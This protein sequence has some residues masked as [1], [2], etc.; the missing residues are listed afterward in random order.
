[1]AVDTADKRITSAFFGMPHLAGVRRPTASWSVFLRGSTIG[2]YH[3]DSIAP[4]DAPGN[5]SSGWTIG[6]A[7]RT[8]RVPEN[9]RV[10]PVGSAERVWRLPERTR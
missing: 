1:M 2:L 3:I 4:P 7:E 8:F 5:P 9:T 6:A 10:W